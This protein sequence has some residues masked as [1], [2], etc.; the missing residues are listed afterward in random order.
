M[1]KFNLLL[2]VMLMLG[3]TATAADKVKISV[4]MNS[5][6]RSMTLADADNE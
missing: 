4:V 2:A 6:S 5:V 3:I 1:K